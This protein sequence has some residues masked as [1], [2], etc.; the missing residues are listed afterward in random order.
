MIENNKE[1]KSKRMTG[2]K[3]IVET[4]KSLGVDTIFGIPGGVVLLLYDELMKDGKIRH[5]LARHEQGATHMAEGYAKVTGKPGAVLVTSGPGATNTIT[6]IADAY[7]DSVP[8]F[9]ITGQVPTYFIGND[10]FQETDSTGISRMIT[11]YN[12]IVKRTEDLAYEIIKAYNISKSGRPG[13]TLVDIPKDV[14]SNEIDF[15][16]PENIK[17]PE[18]HKLDGNDRQ[19]EVA[20]DLI[21]KSERPIIYAGGG[22][23]SSGASEELEELVDITGIPV[24]LTLMGLGGFDGTRPEFLGMLGMHGTYTANMAINNSDLIIAVGSRFDDR[25]TG[26][27]EY[28]APFAKIIHIDIDPASIS[29]NV[30]IDVPIVGD[31]KICLRKMINVLKDT[32]KSKI[33]NFRERIS[34]WWGKIRDWQTK[35]PLKYKKSDSKIKPQ[36]LI[37]ATYEITKNDKVIISTDVGQHQMWVAQYYKIREPRTFLTSGGLGTMG[38]GFPAIIGAKIAKPDRLGICFS[39]DGSFQMNMQELSVAVEE[40]VGVRVIIFNNGAHG[41]VTQWQRKFYGNRYS[42]SLFHIQPD[43]KKLAE[44]FGAKGY[45]IEKPSEL[46]EK[47]R[48]AIK[49][50]PPDVPVIIDVKVDPEEDVYPMVPP[51]SPPTEML[52]S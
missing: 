13:P 50:E 34:S 5:I 6:G 44:A 22:V 20:V 51:G 29:K 1:E 2:A 19:I 46:K 12:T 18:K 26:N 15:T 9:V 52:I 11:K 33:K 47:L 35:Y 23:I 4:L 48:K 14:I 3:I 42:A 10:A 21:L 16:L 38:F 32:P 30:D 7:M 49:E 31:A 28:F 45:V 39:G 37:E 40:K 27:V 25:V 36:E 43:Y 24:T 17:L 41:M 8:L